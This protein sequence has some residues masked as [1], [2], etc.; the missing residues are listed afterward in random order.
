MRMG[1]ASRAAWDSMTPEV[2][3]ARDQKIMR[4]RLARNI[5]APHRPSATW[6]AGWREVGGVRLYARSRWEANIARYLEFLKS[7]GQIAAWAHEPETFWFE[8]IRRGVRSY[9]PDFRVT[10]T[11]GGIYYVEVKGWMDSRSRTTLR[12]MKKYHPLVK[13]DLI[14]TRRYRVLHSQCR[15][16]VSGW[17]S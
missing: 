5:G 17:E 10:R 16:M 9:K 7:H 1:W 14:D 8:A 3:M 12:R 4:T 15:A 2:R 6:K 11:D 13:I